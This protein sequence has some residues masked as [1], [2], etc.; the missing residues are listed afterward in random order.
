[1]KTYIDTSLLVAYYS[2]EPGSKTAESYLVNQSSLYIS[3]LTKVELSS[4]IRKKVLLKELRNEEAL[5]INNAFKNDIS[6]GYYQI[7]PI[8]LKDYHKAQL[9]LSDFSNKLGLHALDAIHIAVAKRENLNLATCDK[10][11]AK[12]AQKIGVTTDF[13]K[14]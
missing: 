14:F 2:P 9:L 11:L 1:L 13:I 3:F 10:Q 12:N 8:V 7:L 6:D 4:A 5:L